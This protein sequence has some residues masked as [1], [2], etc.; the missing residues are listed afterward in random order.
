M[1]IPRKP[2]A[3][4]DPHEIAS[5]F[6]EIVRAEPAVQRLWVTPHRGGIRL[7]LLTKAMD[8][9]DELRLYGLTDHIY[10]R[11]GEVPVTL[12]LLSPRYFDPLDLEVAV[13]P[14]AEEIALSVA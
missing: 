11:F 7:W 1:A 6:A 2:D 12:H 13:P 3:R 4:V 5:A 10:D 14:G 8:S 9:S